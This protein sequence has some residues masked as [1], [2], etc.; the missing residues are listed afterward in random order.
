MVEI[1]R[2]GLFDFL[3]EGV[4]LEK[5]VVFLFLNA[6]GDCF[7]I[8]PGEVARGGFALFFG[9]GAFEC[10]EFLHG[11][12]IVRAAEERGDFGEGKGKIRIRKSKDGLSERVND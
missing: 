6:L 11:F 8:A 3:V 10:D 2:G 5:R 4:A 7:F 9:F 1:K 12:E